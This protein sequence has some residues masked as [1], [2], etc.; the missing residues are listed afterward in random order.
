MTNKK[1]ITVLY[2]DDEPTN[3]MVFELNFK[4]K[5]NVVTAISGQEGLSKLENNTEIIVVISDM[6]MPEMTGI[7]FIKEA[8][9]RFTNVVYFILTGYDITEEIAEALDENVIHE[10]FR[11]PFNMR[12]INRAIERAV[13]KF[14]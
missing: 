5:Y 12:E 8:K 4:I 10:Y 7:E 9:K 6:K 3:L 1:N 13:K 14:E 2:V 11:K